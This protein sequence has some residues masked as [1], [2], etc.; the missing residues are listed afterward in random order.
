VPQ[1]DLFEMTDEHEHFAEE[2]TEA[3]WRWVG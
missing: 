2:L 3:K 1:I